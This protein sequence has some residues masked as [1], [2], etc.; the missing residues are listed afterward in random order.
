[1][2][3]DDE[4]PTTADHWLSR[5]EGHL[6]LATQ[7]K[8]PAG[9]WE[10]LAFH[11]QQAAEFALKAVY[12]NRNLTFRFTHSIEELGTGLEEAG[13]VVPDD[14]KEAV[15]LTRYAVRARYPGVGPPVTRQEHQDAVRLA[16]AVVRWT[17]EEVGS[18][19]S[20]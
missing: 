7:R 5:A 12:Q 14:V 4:D 19:R 10:D 11:A 15:V 13:V 9:F 1:M 3:L 16:E 6:A 20:R 17:K 8:P 2:P 18:D